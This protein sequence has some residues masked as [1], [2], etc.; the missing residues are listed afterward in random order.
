MG[1][2][3]DL[4][5]KIPLLRSLPNYLGLI[6]YKHF[7]PTGTQAGFGKLFRDTDPIGLLHRITR[8]GGLGRID[9][10][11]AVGGINVK[12]VRA[13]TIALRVGIQGV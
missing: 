11:T 9:V 6:V 3:C 2:K 4:R 5:V 1:E 7:V 13:V 10:D 12:V 8:T